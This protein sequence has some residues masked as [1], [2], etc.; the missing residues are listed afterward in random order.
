MEVDEESPQLDQPPPA[1]FGP[2]NSYL[3]VAIDGR[4][5]LLATAPRPPEA[6]PT[7]EETPCYGPIVN[8]R[9]RVNWQTSAELRPT[10]Y[11]QLAME[12]PPIPL[13]NGASRGGTAARAGGRS[14]I[15]GG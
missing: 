8:R 4:A 10:P 14:G 2:G 7:E 3:D 12:G 6:A 5:A 15:R 1:D 11:P 13:G 9:R